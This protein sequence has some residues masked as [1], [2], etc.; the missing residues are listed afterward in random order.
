M[1]LTSLAGAMLIGLST[2]GCSY[3]LGSPFGDR[4]DE[5]PEYTHSSQPRPSA[6][7][8]AQVPGAAD[9]DL[10]MAKAAAAEALSRGG[11]DVSVPWENPG[12]GARGTVTPIALSYTRDGF[13]CH[14]F[15]ASVVHGSDESWLQGEA[16]RLHRG[17]WEVTTLKP[18]KR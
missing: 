1:R 7:P 4:D 14:D 6:L 12:T 5:K 9:A 10:G 2:G 18:L 16:C 15:L 8:A 11:K 13:V 17:R 3:K